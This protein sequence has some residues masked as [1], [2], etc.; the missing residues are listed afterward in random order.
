MILA[1]T[2]RGRTAT[3][4]FKKGSEK[5]VERVLGKGSEKGGPFSMG[6]TVKKGALRRVLRRGSEKGVNP[7]G[8]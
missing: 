2:V 3:Q 8:S 4:S 7:E 5:V 6:F 1:L